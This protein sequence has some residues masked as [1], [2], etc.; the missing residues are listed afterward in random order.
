MRDGRQHWAGGVGC[1]GP[2]A[3]LPVPLDGLGRVLRTGFLSGQALASLASAGRTRTCHMVDIWRTSLAG[4][5]GCDSGCRREGS[6]V[7]SGW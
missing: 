2:T 5:E 6:W 3:C 1:E 7:L 4:L